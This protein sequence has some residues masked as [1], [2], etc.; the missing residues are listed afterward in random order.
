MTDNIIRGVQICVLCVALCAGA[1]V[2]AIAAGAALWRYMYTLRRILQPAQLAVF[3]AAASVCCMFAQKSGHVMFPRTDAD[4]AYLTDRGSYVTNDYV[5][6]DFAR[7]IVP[8]DAHVYVDY[9][10][11]DMTNDWDWV[12]LLESTFAEFAVPTNVPFAAATNYDWMV[13]TDWTPGP[14]VQTN[15]V[16]H[17]LWGMDQRGNQHLIPI[18]TTV[19]VD[20]DTIATPKSKEEAQ[21]END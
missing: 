12:T 9:R 5:H 20:G 14:T 2:V 6:I 18:R 7:I 15:G 3:V 8:N 1:V 16:W 11:L 4:A 21:H 10:R 13:Y 17:A 19:R